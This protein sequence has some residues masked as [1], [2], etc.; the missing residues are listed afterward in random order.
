MYHPGRR[1][2]SLLATPISKAAARQRAGRAGRQQAGKCFR[3]FTEDTYS[4]LTERNVPEIQRTSLSA[5]L[6]ALK[7]RQRTPAA[8]RAVHP[9]ARAHARAAAAARTGSARFGCARTGSAW[10]RSNEPGRSLPTRRLGMI[11]SLEHTIARPL[12]MR[13]RCTAA[14]RL[15]RR[16]GRHAGAAT[17]T[18]THTWFLSVVYRV[19]TTLAC[20]A[21]LQPTHCTKIPTPCFRPVPPART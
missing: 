12:H 4:E 1:I 9:P 2:D 14:E 3:L 18:H 17:H 5:A 21:S 8:R 6:L 11:S 19:H 10:L 7:V 15:P 16:R 20:S 13:P